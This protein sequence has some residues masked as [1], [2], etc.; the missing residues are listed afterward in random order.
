MKRWKGS[1]VSQT[2]ESPKDKV[3]GTERTIT[4]FQTPTSELT[5]NKRRKHYA[6]LS[7][8]DVPGN[9]KELTIQLN[10]FNQEN[11]HPDRDSL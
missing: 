11:N 10:L 1:E 6:L 8:R 2:R 4:L 5:E 9:L 3:G 7:K